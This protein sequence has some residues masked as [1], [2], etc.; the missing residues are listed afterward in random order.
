MRYFKA[1]YGD[2][3]RISPGTFEGYTAGVD[4]AGK[5]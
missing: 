4:V 3:K 2:P 5:L 1:L